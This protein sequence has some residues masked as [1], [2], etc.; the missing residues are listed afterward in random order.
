MELAGRLGAQTQ[1]MESV[2]AGTSVLITSAPGHGATRFVEGVAAALRSEM[3]DVV[4]LR[5]SDAESAVP[6]AVLGP[7]LERL[8]LAG[9]EPL[10]VYTELPPALRR[11]HS[12]VVVDDAEMLDRATGVL[13]GQL[14]RT[15]VVA[16]VT[17]RQR[18]ELPRSVRDELAA[19]HCSTVDLVAL[20]VDDTLAL[21]AAH[22][23][24]ELDSDA[25]AHVLALSE[26]SP[27]LLIDLVESSTWKLGSTGARHVTLRPGAV[28]RQV[29]EER[30]GPLSSRE[31]EVLTKLAVADMLP[32]QLLDPA[33]ATALQNSGAVVTA[34]DRTDSVRLARPLD[35][36]VTVADLAPAEVSR[37]RR[38]L[39]TALQT[40]DGWDAEAMLLLV[41]SGTS[42]EPDHAFSAAERLWSMGAIDA[43]AEVLTVLENSSDPRVLLLTATVAADR[44]ELDTALRLL[45]AATSLVDTDTDRRRLGQQL[46]LLH[47]V[48]LMD[49]T[50]AVEAVE[51]VLA[52][53][54]DP[55]ERRVLEA[56]LV[57]WRLMAGQPSTGVAPDASA[58]AHTRLTE[59][60]IGAMIASMDGTADE[61]AV[62]VT[63]GRSLLPQ[64]PDAEAWVSDLLGLSEFLG[65]AFDGTILEAETR[66]RAARDAA[67]LTGDSALGMWE[68]AAAET[69]LHRGE[70]RQV[71]TLARRAVRHLAWR[72]FTGLGP[73]ATAL[74]AVSEA[75][76]GRQSSADRIVATLT[77]SQRLDS[78]VALHLARV[79]AEQLLATSPAAAAQELEDAAMTAAAQ[80][81]RHLATLALDEAMMI[82]PTPDR[83]SRLVSLAAGRGLGDLLGSRAMAML[84]DQPADLLPWIDR[85]LDVGLIGRA[86]HLAA[87]A[88]DRL[89]GVGAA[90]QASV[91]RRRAVLLGSDRGAVR[92]PVIDGVRSLT[93][94]ELD[95]ARLAS[96]RVRS[97]EIAE[98]LGLSVRT[99]D[100][101]LARA[102]RKLGVSTRDELREVT[103][104]EDELPGS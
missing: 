90:E 84:T 11:R 1:V 15:G 55:S 81:H 45:G 78:K 64:V 59:A 83:A 10:R 21:A 22:V 74:V 77:P 66:A 92:W 5:G 63:A 8:G 93:R 25:A 49:P 17:C 96:G 95:I 34:P 73:T 72:D 75:R 46:G 54:T 102:Y 103:A 53:I 50:R 31:V 12:V 26:R 104:L 89:G 44:G 42:V 69:A 98:R 68:Y 70:A 23:G 3:R 51:D 7:D 87:V 18:T 24:D 58:A 36:L 39:G 33:A 14:I 56:D 43:A 88:A 13:L 28:A 101:H 86:A 99:V 4:F 62:A 82:A 76:A 41:R 40:I 47:G 16:V 27:A 60:V 91:L 94:R 71:A 80:M 100:N 30:L 19:R 35:G 29:V 37:V 61:V 85:L 32:V 52:D 79:T 65:E 57:K 67:A 9:A 97:R 6:L 2:R 38:A 48:R 20:S